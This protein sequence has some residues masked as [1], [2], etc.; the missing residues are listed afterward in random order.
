VVLMERISNDSRKT[1]NTRM[2]GAAVLQ[3][4]LKVVRQCIHYI[5]NY[6][7]IYIYICIFVYMHIHMYLEG[8]IH[9]CI[10]TCMYV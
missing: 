1:G 8:Y 3:P 5:Y 4:G 7:Y 9:I 6:I 2:G 10:Y